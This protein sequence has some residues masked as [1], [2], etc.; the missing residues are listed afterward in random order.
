MEEIV[1]SSRE[2]KKWSQGKVERSVQ[3]LCHEGIGS[4]VE[5]FWVYQ[6]MPVLNAVLVAFDVLGAGQT[7]QTEP[8]VIFGVNY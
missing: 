2:S 8:E 7:W 6:V 5:L 1:L 4:S 3:C